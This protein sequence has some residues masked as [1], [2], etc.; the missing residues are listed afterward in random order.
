[1]A[2]ESLETI[3]EQLGYDFGQF[4]LADFIRHIERRN[5]RE[6]VVK[7]VPFEFGLSAIW[8][9]AE[10]ADYIFYNE[11]THGIHSTHNIL[12][13]IAHIVLEHTCCPVEEMLLPELVALVREPQ[14]KGRFRTADRQSRTE[15]EEQEAELFVFLIQKR[16]MAANRITQLMGQSSS[17]GALQQWVESMAFDR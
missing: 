17:I 10:T 16:L 5:R 6:I 2:R 13:E 1:M 11:R 3:I 4:E 12:H 15:R 8:V 7:G 9:H 14:P